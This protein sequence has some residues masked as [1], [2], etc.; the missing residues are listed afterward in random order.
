[1]Q[2]DDDSFDFSED[3]QRE[4]RSLVEGMF[5]TDTGCDVIQPESH[6]LKNEDW[7]YRTKS[8]SLRKVETKCDEYHKTGNICVELYAT[9]KP[10]SFRNVIQRPI[11]KSLTIS[12]KA[13]DNTEYNALIKAVVK[14]EIEGSKG[15]G[16]SDDLSGAHDFYYVFLDKK[17]ECSP[18][19]Y[20]FSANDV[21]AYIKELFS[22]PMEASQIDY[23]FFI[24]T[25]T[26]QGR[27]WNTLGILV[28]ESDLAGAEDGSVRYK[29][30]GS[31]QLLSHE[32]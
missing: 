1:M 26:Y 19:R 28:P 10:H 23:T 17:N 12:R 13:F 16:L 30:Y 21:N 20:R 7:S 31:L 24:T 8:G 25:S 15:L 11:G 6:D 27:E 29:K 22:D 5:V 14:G 18:R 3:L 32:I 9:A 2:N 4:N